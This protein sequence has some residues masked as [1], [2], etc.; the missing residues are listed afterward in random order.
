MKKITAALL[1]AG[2][3]AALLP[4]SAFAAGTNGDTNLALGDGV[5]VLAYYSH[6][7]PND[8]WGLANINDG[9]PIE[10]V[11]SLGNGKAGGYHSMYYSNEADQEPQYVG[12]NFGKKVTFNTVV[13]TPTT[14]GIFPVDFEIQVSNDG[15][16]WTSVV[17]KTDYAITSTAGYV[18]QTFEFAS[19]T[20]QYV[21]IY[22]TKLNRDAYNYAMKLTEMEV[23][24]LDKADRPVN[25]AAGKPVES[26]SHIDSGAWNLTY[27]NDGDRMNLSTTNLDY[28]QFAGYHNSLDTPALDGGADAHIQVTIDLGAG[29]KFNEVVIYP[30]HEVYS[31]KTLNGQ[32]E[33]EAYP[34]GVYFPENYQIQVSDDGETW[35]TVKTVTNTPKSDINPVVLDF[36][37]VTARYVRLYMEKLT[38]NIKL[39]EFEVYD[40]TS[41]SDPVVPNPAETGSTLPALVCLG[42]TAIAAGIC[43]IKRRRLAFD[44]KQK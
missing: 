26:D 17:T 10:T 7:D 5:E 25:I 2:L 35:K 29:S 40:T 44:V 43:L 34:L 24:N 33:N 1:L 41:A 18:P 39:S 22:A 13:V 4:T 30:S 36:D 6:E 15:Q 32:V 27:F 3:C 9:D 8:N 16:N 12:Y 14:A 19:Q 42:G 11:G 37:S 28:G 21:R 20:A 31:V 38:H 23:Y